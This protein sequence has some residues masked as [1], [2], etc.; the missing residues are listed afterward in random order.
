MDLEM[1]STLNSL[2]DRFIRYVL[3]LE[4]GFKVEH[5]Q[6]YHVNIFHK[7]CYIGI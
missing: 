2:R 4:R 3:N 5:R 1:R 6:Y 7:K